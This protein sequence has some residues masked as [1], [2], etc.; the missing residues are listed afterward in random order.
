MCVCVYIYIYIYIYIYL[1]IYLFICIGSVIQ[2]MNYRLGVGFSEQE[3]LRIFCD[4][5]EAVSRLHHC[6]TPIVHRDLK[7]KIT[8]YMI[9]LAIHLMTVISEI[10]SYLPVYSQIVILVYGSRFTVSSGR[11]V[12]SWIC[13]KFWVILFSVWLWTSYL[14]LVCMKYIY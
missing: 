6:Q 9:F 8:S 4:V 5:C 14:F 3:V 11:R 13:C 10:Y 12:F 1:F 7:V 2:L